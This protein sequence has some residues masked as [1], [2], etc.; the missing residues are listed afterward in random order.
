VAD[1]AIRVQ[2][3]DGLV[4]YELAVVDASV[5]GLGI[6]LEPPL[7]EKTVGSELELWVLLPGFEAFVARASLRHAVPRIGV[8]GVQ[9][10]GLSDRNQAALQ[11]VVGELLAR[12]SSV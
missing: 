6:S 1:Y 4:T 3:R 12:G 8:C 11:H 9:L 2:L 7:T 10:L 5:G